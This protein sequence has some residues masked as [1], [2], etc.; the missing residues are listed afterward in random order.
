MGQTQTPGS[1]RWIDLTAD[2]A[3]G[4]RDFYA[5][6]AGWSAEP[7]SMGADQ[8]YCKCDASGAPPRD[9]EGMGRACVI[10]D[11]AGAVCALFETA[12]ED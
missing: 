8:D 10:R 7:V 11:P 12:A 6:V 9:F 2:D 4:I 1:I 3:E 5:A